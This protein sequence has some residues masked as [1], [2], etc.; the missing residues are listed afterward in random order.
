MARSLAFGRGFGSSLFGDTGPTALVTPVYAYLLAGVFKVFGIYSAQ[1]AVVILSIN[2]L[3]SALTCIPIFFIAQK[4][5]GLA[6]ARR[7]GWAWVFFPY[8]IAFAATRVW[9]DCLNALLISLIVL[10]VLHLAES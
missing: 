10:M 9:G 8:A 2:S 1:S 6:V 4:S 3:C 5:F 7:A